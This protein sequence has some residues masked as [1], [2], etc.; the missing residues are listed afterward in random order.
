MQNN[1]LAS[2]LL[3]N[4]CN[5]ICLL[6]SMVVSVLWRNGLSRNFHENLLLSTL[7]K[8]DKIDFATRSNCLAQSFYILEPLLYECHHSDATYCCE[9]IFR[10]LL[11]PTNMMHGGCE[12]STTFEAKLPTWQSSKSLWPEREKK[13]NTG[14][15]I[16]P[17]S[18]WHVFSRIWQSWSLITFCFS[19][20]CCI[21]R[22]LGCCGGLSLKQTIVWYNTLAENL[23]KRLAFPLKKI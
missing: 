1:F 22:A 2:V 23:D 6:S 17:Y 7:Y 21:L 10:F 20:L 14:R 13:N 8:T 15:I 16:N 12:K 18:F 5:I 4:F 11:L 3:N 19:K 9:S